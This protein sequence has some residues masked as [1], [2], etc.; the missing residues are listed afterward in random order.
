MDTMNWELREAIRENNVPE[1]RR[2][3]RSVGAA[4]TG[5]KMHDSQGDRIGFSIK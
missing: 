5:S 1:V 4:V 2:L 3:L